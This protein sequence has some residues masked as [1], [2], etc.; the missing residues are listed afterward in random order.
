MWRR[1]RERDA[2]QLQQE[3]PLKQEVS[4]RMCLKTQ[5]DQKR[6]KWEKVA[7]FHESQPARLIIACVTPEE[8][9]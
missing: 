8:G 3:K 1:V 6:L 9:M 5:D 4:N 2:R 7:M